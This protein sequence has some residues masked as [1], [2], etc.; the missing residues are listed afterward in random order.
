MKTKML[1]WMALA[2]T[3]VV[4]PL[5]QAADIYEIVPCNDVGTPRDGFP[6]VVTNYVGDTIYFKLRLMMPLVG[7]SAGEKWTLKY[8]G[9]WSW[10]E[11][12]KT[13]EV[14]QP[15][16]IGLSISGRR[17]WATYHDCIP[18]SAANGNIADFIFS[19]TIQPGDF[20]QPIR[21]AAND[22]GD[23]ISGDTASLL[24]RNSAVWSIEAD[25][26]D[27]GTV[28]T[29]ILKIAASAPEATYGDSLSP[30]YSTGRV[31]DYS[32]SQAGFYVH[33]VNFDD[34]WEKPGEFWRVVHAGS[35]QTAQYT[36]K[37]LAKPAVDKP[38]TFYVW[39]TDESI[40]KVNSDETVNLETN[41]G[42]FVNNV[43]VKKIE[44]KATDAFQNFE[45]V[46]GDE[47]KTNQTAYLVLSP[48]NKYLYD[49]SNHRID[50]F[51]TI[52]VT[53]GPRLPP[54]I[55]VT[56]DPLKAVAN[57]D[58]YKQA[59]Q[60]TIKLS[61]AYT[62][63]F[64]VLIE[65]I[66]TS[67]A[68]EPGLTVGDYVRLYDQAEWTEL[69]ASTNWTVKFTKEGMAAEGGLTKTIY[70]YALRSD[71][72]TLGDINKIRLQPTIPDTSPNKADADIFFENLNSVALNIEAAPATLTL[73]YDTSGA[74][75]LSVSAGQN[76]SMKI[77][78]SDTFADSQ[79]TNFGYQVWFYPEVSDPA[80]GIL[81]GDFN[82]DVEGYLVDKN[83]AYPAI[84]YPAKY[85]QDATRESFIRVFSP[86]S[87][88]ESNAAHFYANVSR[89]KT[90]SI[91]ATDNVTFYNERLKGVEEM[92]TTNGLV[93]YK[94]S[95]SEASDVNLWAF[96]KPDATLNPDMSL[97]GDA[98]GLNCI[99]NPTNLAEGAHFGI[100]INALSV[101]PVAGALYVYD[102]T[103]MGRT[104]SFEV[105]LCSQNEFN[106][107]YVVT[108]YNTSKI[109]VRV[110]NTEPRVTGAAINNVSVGA[111]LN[112]TID[113]DGIPLYRYKMPR[114]QT[115]SIVPLI[116]DSSYDL[117]S[118]FTYKVTAVCGDMMPYT[119]NLTVT[120][121]T[122]PAWEYA[123]K[124]RGIWTITLEAQDKDMSVE[125]WSSSSYTFRLEI[126]TDPVVGITVDPSYNEYP[127][128]GNVIVSLPNFY[129]DDYMVVKLRVDLPVDP[130]G[131]TNGVFKLNRNAADVGSPN[132]TL[133]PSSLLGENEYYVVIYDALVDGGT[134]I[135]IAEMDGT[136]LTASSA[137]GV[138]LT[139]TVIGDQDGTNSTYSG[140]LWGNYYKE[141]T[142]SPMVVNVAPQM[143]GVTTQ[144]SNVWT[145]AAAL[146]TERTILF[147][148]DGDA[149]ADKTEGVDIQVYGCSGTL[150]CG[151]VV[152]N[153]TSYTVKNFPAACEFTPNFTGM[154][155]VK[156]VILKISDKDGGSHTYEYT[157]TV[158]ASKYLYTLANGP[159]REL[160]SA[161]SKK[162]AAASGRGAGRIYT[163]ESTITLGSVSGFKYAWN[164]GNAQ[165]ATIV[166]EGY[167]TNE[168]DNVLNKSGN[169]WVSG[170]KYQYTEVYDSYL[171]TWLVHTGEDSG[172]YA[173]A[174]AGGL[175]PEYTEEVTVPAITIKLPKEA[176]EDGV[177]E[178]VYYEAVFSK[179]FRPSDNAGDI[180]QDGIP[181]R[182]VLKYGFG[183]VDSD[184]GSVSGNDVGS[185]S[186]L[187]SFNDDEDFMPKYTSAGNPTVPNV[188]SEWE[189]ND[190]L[191]FVA[192]LEIRGY[193]DGLNAYPNKDGNYE[194]DFSD[195]EKRAFI[196]W[197]GDYE[198]VTSN[199]VDDIVTEVTNTWTGVRAAL[200]DENL[201]TN[202]VYKAC[203]DDLKILNETE[204]LDLWANKYEALAVAALKA[205]TWSPEN[206]SDPTKYDTDEDTLPDGYEYWFW[207]AAKVGFAKAGV[208]EGPLIGRRFNID[209]F[210]YDP[211][212]PETILRA[213]DPN[214]DGR[215]AAFGDIEPLLTRDLDN[216]GLYD[217]EEF[218]IGSNP[219]DYDT[220]GGGVPDGYE[221]MWDLNPLTPG[222]DAGNPDGDAM[223]F[224]QLGYFTDVTMAIWEDDKWTV[225]LIP[226]SR[227]PH[228]N[229]DV[230]KALSI[231]KFNEGTPLDYNTVTNLMLYPDGKGGLI[232]NGTKLFTTTNAVAPTQEDY[233][234][235][236]G[237]DG[238]LILNPDVVT[239]NEDLSPIRKYTIPLSS[240]T[241]LSRV[242]IPDLNFNTYA[243]IHDQVFRV[244]GF[245][246]RTGWTTGCPHGYIAGRWCVQCSLST[247]GDVDDDRVRDVRETGLV[248]NTASYSTYDEFMLGLYRKKIG[249]W[250]DPAEENKFGIL[251]KNHGL[252]DD[253]VINC[254]N[255]NRPGASNNAGNAAAG[256][257]PETQIP[258]MLTQHGADTDGDGRPDGWELYCAFDPNAPDGSMSQ[259]SDSDSEGSESGE[260]SEEDVEK[261]VDGD[262]D[263]D[264]LPDA[265]E[266]AGTDSC[267]AYSTCDSIAKNA[268]TNGWVNK[269]FPTNPGFNSKWSSL[270]IE[271]RPDIVRYGGP[272]TDG[273]GISDSEE[274][275]IWEAVFQAGRENTW[276]TYVFSFIYPR[277]AEEA[278]KDLVCYRGGGMNPC[279]V[280]TDYDGIPDGWERQHAG[281]LVDGSYTGSMY[282]ETMR[283]AD[284]IYLEEFT[285]TEKYITGGMD[286]TDRLDGYTRTYQHADYNAKDPRTNTFRDRDFD[287]DGL[288]NYQE[289]LTQAIRAWR[290]DD[291]ETPLMGRV[292][293]W[294]K[295][296]R[297]LI[298]Q[299]DKAT[300]YTEMNVTDGESY[301]S[302]VA[303]AFGASYTSGN[304]LYEYQKNNGG[305]DDLGG[306][307]YVALGYFAPPDHEWDPM[308]QQGLHFRGKPLQFMR[309]PQTTR[310]FE[311]EERIKAWETVTGGITN[312]FTNIVKQAVI[313]RY[314]ASAYASTDPRRWD[315]DNDG[316][317]DYWE[318]FHGLNPLLGSLMIPDYP[319][320]SHYAEFNYYSENPRDIVAEAYRGSNPAIG[321]SGSALVRTMIE[322]E[323]IEITNDEP[324]VVVTTNAG[325]TE[326]EE[327]DSSTRLPISDKRNYWVEFGGENGHDPIL[328]PWRLGG[329]EADPDG[330]GL[331]N[332][333]ESMA[334]NLST[335]QNYHTDP[336]P[337]WMTDL[338][339]WLSHTRQYYR[340]GSLYSM[341]NDTSIWRMDPHT[342]DH[343]TSVSEGG[344]RAYL[345]P[346]EQTE[347]F[348]S[349][350]DW[351]GDAYE[352]V[353]NVLPA[354]DA[355]NANDP[356]RRA[357]LYLNGDKSLAHSY[358]AGKVVNSDAY[359]TFRQFTVECW[360]KP[361]GSVTNRTQ[362]ILERGY[363]YPAA[364][365]QNSKSVWR[366]N[367]RL[368]ITAEGQ[369]RGLFNN[370][371]ATTNDTV[372]STQDVLGG[373]I[374]PG[375]WTHIALTYN[376]SQ[377]AIYVN[378]K[379]K[380]YEPTNLIPANGI[381]AIYQDPSYV[382]QENSNR[383]TFVAYPGATTIG[384]RRMLTGGQQNDY[385]DFNPTVS[386][387]SP[388]AYNYPSG[389]DYPR[390]FENYFENYYQG[391]VSEV[392]FWDGARTAA[393]I[394][395]TYKSRFTTDDVAANR[396]EVYLKWKDGATRS[397]T[398]GKAMLPAQLMTHYNFQQ[399]P[400]ALVATNVVQTPTGFENGVLANISAEENVQKLAEVGTH[401][402]G[403]E[404]NLFSTIYQSK[405]V[406]PWIEN[407]VSHLPLLDGSFADSA[408]WS[409]N[410]IGSISSLNY[411]KAQNLGIPNGGNPYK[412]RIYMSDAELHYWRLRRF[413]E[414]AAQ[415]GLTGYDNAD[416]HSRRYRFEVRSL[417]TGTDDLVPM[418]GA[419]AK[420]SEDYWDEQG[421]TTAWTDTGTDS[422]ADGLPDW[423]EKLYDTDGNVDRNDLVEYNGMMIP[424]YEAYLRDLAAGMQPGG[425][426][427]N[428]YVNFSDM[429]S[430]GLVDWWQQLHDVKGGSLGD[431]D[432]DG[433]SNYME[434][435]L[436]EA[437]K[438]GGG[439]FS[440]TDA[441]SVNPN[442]SD[443]FYK[444]GASYAGEI[445]TDHD[446]MSDTWE[447][448]Y[449][450]V[451]SRYRYDA[452]ED[453]DNEENANFDGDGD[454][455][456]NFAEFMAGTSP[457]VSFNKSIDGAVLAEYPVPII[458]VKAVYA[459]TQMTAPL[460]VK[461]W[462]DETLQAKPDAVWTVGTTTTTGSTGGSTTGSASSSTSSS[463]KREK[464]IGRNPGGL[465]TYNLS[466]GN[467]NPGTVEIAVK[468][469]KW[470]RYNATTGDVY[471]NEAST[472]IWKPLVNDII[473]NSKGDLLCGDTVV[474]SIS[475]TTGQMTIDFSLL[476]EEIHIVGDITD[477]E[478]TGEGTDTVYSIYNLSRSYV[479]ISWEAD[480]VSGKT[481]PIY[482]LT[483]ADLP[484]DTNNSVGY[485]KEGRNT[486]VAFYDLDNDGKYTAGEPYGVAP[487]VN[488][489]WDSAVVQI[490][491][492]DTSPI[493]ARFSVK[494][495]AN[496]SSS[497]GSTSSSTT[498]TDGNQTTVQ[499]DRTYLYGIEAGH[500]DQALVIEGKPSGGVFQRVRVIRTFING[501][502]CYN[503]DGTNASGYKPCVVLDKELNVGND[504]YITEADFLKNCSFD[505]DW[506][507]LASD[508]V[509]GGQG[510]TDITNV[511]Y[512][513]VLGDGDISNFTTNNLLGLAFNR[514]FEPVD[515]Y[516]TGAKPVATVLGNVTTVSPTFEWVIPNNST[517]YTAF[518]VRVT[519][520]SGAA[521]WRSDFQPM[522]P[523]IQGK[524]RWTPPLYAN[525]LTLGG[526]KFENN[527]TYRYEISIANARYR[528]LSEFTWS[529]KA[530]FTMCV[531]MKEQDG[532]GVAVRYYGTP[533]AATNKAIRVQAF[534]TP[535]FSGTPV[536]EGY[537]SDFALLASTNDTT[538]ANVRLI[539]LSS[540]TYYLRAFIDTQADGKRAAWESWG[541]PCL[542]DQPKAE[543]FTAR[544]VTV[545]ASSATHDVV[546]IFIE[547][548]DMDHDGL[549]DAWEWTPAGGL[550]SL[551]T[552]SYNPTLPDGVSMS[553]GLLDALNMN[554]TNGSAMA[555]VNAE[556]ISMLS[557]LTHSYRAAVLL[558]ANPA[559]I[560]GSLKT[561]LADQ[562]VEPVA[563][564]VTGIEIAADGKIT[565]DVDAVAESSSEIAP[566]LQNIYAV[567][568]GEV[569]A[570]L[571]VWTTNDLSNPTWTNIPAATKEI[572]L[573]AGEI[574]KVLDTGVTATGGS[575]FYKVTLTK[576]AE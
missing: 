437:L 301:L 94:I 299:K 398:D 135:P 380:K 32:L 175:S 132:E 320:Y 362:T 361:E 559:D 542:R 210:G 96:L 457:Q 443:Y 474:G 251:Q 309:L 18:A 193:H 458:Q 335:A 347:G 484:S 7:N 413:A 8:S 86:I 331:R 500:L 374:E 99:L 567:G 79:T 530:T 87:K 325:Y 45:L 250:F 463:A 470:Q 232:F 156:T 105:V 174:H 102:G 369:I 435:I 569:K 536:S 518:R 554:A 405:Y 548:C 509:A 57:G 505:I 302:S 576:V 368:E 312:C 504:A 428:A 541:Y 82:L 255:P 108:T 13:A 20:A 558:G 236:L 103:S 446:R 365:L 459:G 83:G 153:A 456:S 488:V 352:L 341:F 256:T 129:A 35:T 511:T 22:L 497:S 512:R 399:L 573:T 462:R 348:D 218:V 74:R 289:Y 524:Y 313:T 17:V 52:P 269:F 371:A 491:L 66:L 58:R 508:L 287:Q 262:R 314:K 531:P 353:K 517:S 291:T 487:N 165:S 97:Y 88:K 411:N 412:S 370:S 564:S 496:G 414:S 110:L 181:D 501:Q 173:S 483:D 568:S 107:N 62:N 192:R 4:A 146:A 562:T 195:D 455:W 574:G 510:T 224:A 223:A 203:I 438:L 384:A 354:S 528:N 14:L 98:T 274:G 90:V 516:K 34:Q 151:G 131:K 244:Y 469:V 187:A 475:Y 442:L 263:A 406:I 196:L 171:Y 261:L 357:A 550:T 408:F 535:D 563:V 534:T 358:M 464:I 130:S 525:A 136:Q 431:D 114:G 453:K 330:D 28:D 212:S 333:E 33:S 557:A 51:I 119:T 138:Q 447:D 77:K 372:F 444:V 297:K 227:N 529:N 128:G 538:T 238:P 298:D 115:Q 237:E 59:S 247:S 63:D 422:D 429:D 572:T 141:G 280:D 275:M 197:Y 220:D 386:Y 234:M 292:F 552:K 396:E 308:Y 565:I 315:S 104:L 68:A 499:N 1:K 472:A 336:T 91:E 176:S 148:I 355:L 388:D 142:A 339:A 2:A 122:L 15:F 344:S 326:V 350:A 60:I 519:D 177:F 85:V 343:D 276:G 466:P 214:V 259:D 229:W 323:R 397:D 278:G 67:G 421:A 383:D 321:R 159:A 134:V 3:F 445:F 30:S 272:D 378:G 117:K 245:D 281:I 351:V 566:D 166:A 337:L 37:L 473:D 416:D 140:E 268:S 394:E 392:R 286:A 560:D 551:D 533:Y 101:N 490:E 273:D 340:A 243:L 198:F 449:T 545:D 162:Y 523:R 53:V 48:V 571:E 56:A 503:M 19:Y 10:N 532:L 306:Y 240:S 199:L 39:S 100:P 387:N 433:L 324:P 189:S 230:E 403:L 267:A 253:L 389:Y 133:Y 113:A 194:P 47:A 329:A 467:I 338:K 420:L 6:N 215:T 266:F 205:K 75:T 21:F 226:Q 70:L 482:Y 172:S 161:L 109:N 424:A 328:A 55:T 265:M 307:D 180:N 318:V 46:G 204:L 76:E 400:A 317:D 316:M 185:G 561:I 356:D 179:E 527:K 112:H 454:G 5:A 427:D 322:V 364:N 570:L 425:E 468:D 493:T 208:W 434:Y 460:V 160:G 249:Q 26:D 69:P 258:V 116:T 84:N 293:A 379:F 360:V 349:D 248:V 270:A 295:G 207:Y 410:Y 178:D 211:I 481:S 200:P 40:V 123:F 465:V 556:Q 271:Y 522:P 235:F 93:N 385:A 494:S 436:G 377:L 257:V 183:V 520:E 432:G 441:F 450:G 382:N 277:C 228:L 285:G 260:S 139:A 182:T 555:M 294:P 147:T 216:D 157:Y 209:T 479:K 549:P 305:A 288:E 54:S 367:F 168:V 118:N 186:N 342:Y 539:G 514:W 81:L 373:V 43:H 417:V 506:V 393:E 334:A 27:D 89:P 282:T 439:R 125:T 546:T 409:Q 489:G 401:W 41:K 31:N 345:F 311:D 547:D 9:T 264:L 498:E 149:N 246:P 137:G 575:G 423:W 29:A 477:T 471:Q 154:S 478:G 49:S 303:T 407:T 486:F 476:P 24:L 310:S 42:V 507:S 252:L 155:G 375:K 241:L 537:V 36:P 65:P 254:T 391:Y 540:G 191:A 461:A 231:V 92:T 38:V 290:Y 526:V 184:S 111:P 495:D 515:E 225:Y 452:D 190:Q 25:K 363:E 395:Q 145:V 390:N 233:T 242:D 448:L 64:D 359:N 78:V 16:G 376:G 402:A 124:K 219:V 404:D 419:Y 127:G 239:A 544:P 284:G 319:G 221:V 126:L 502:P 206:P 418:G 543:I 150:A 346:F 451:I 222:D 480:S 440:P 426:I 283:I 144:G 279:A 158:I 71:V 366:A 213:F 50:N 521:V 167:K 513:I 44:F 143:S 61:Q 415:G 12:N 202:E 11:T 164:C 430:D 120:A 300:A 163:R 492:T 80:S 95:L 304:D 169:Q 170:E 73:P 381:L 201:G 332:V 188:S 217:W 152:T 121:G 23:P 485:V 553:T 296:S 72:K 106:T 327:K